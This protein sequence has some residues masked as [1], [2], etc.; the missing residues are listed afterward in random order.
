MQRFT[1]RLTFDRPSFV[2]VDTSSNPGL[3]YNIGNAIAFSGALMA[4]VLHALLSENLSGASL[5]SHFIGNAPALLTTVATCVF[6]ISGLAYAKAWDRGFPPHPVFNRRGHALST[7]GAFCIGLALVLMARTEVALALALVATMLHVAGKW[8]S[9]R[10][11]DADQY[12]KPM[13]LYSRVPYAT[14]VLLDLRS[15]M[16]TSASLDEAT[17]KVVLPLFLLLATLFWARAD[18][19]L[20]PQQKTE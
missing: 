6:W 19:L 10:A 18:W 3:L 13:P 2:F 8:V 9:W 5:A 20:L 7:L 15:D 1:N 16:L 11:P 4:F 14:T 12:F 17:I